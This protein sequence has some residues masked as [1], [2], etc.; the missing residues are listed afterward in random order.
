MDQ[1]DLFQLPVPE[2]S[3]DAT[4]PAHLLA[5]ATKIEEA[6][7]NAGAQAKRKFNAASQS[8]SS[9]TYTMLGT[10]DRIQ[11][12]ELENDGTILVA[13]ECDSNTPNTAEWSMVVRI[14]DFDTFNDT[15][16]SAFI[17]TAPGV[18]LVTVP[19]GGI[20]AGLLNHSALATV[21]VPA[22]TYTVQV[23]VKRTAGSGNI[24]LSNRDLRVIAQEYEPA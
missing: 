13:F 9:S 11:N 6:L 18:H 3:D 5:L 8:T 1:T 2:G 22:G 17:T 10:P 4:I 19:A 15:L 16:P 12:I 23:E 21:H 24:Q 14:T 20:T 7:R